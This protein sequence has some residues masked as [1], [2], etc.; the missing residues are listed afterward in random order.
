ML[1]PAYKGNLGIGLLSFWT[2][3]DPASAMT[4]SRC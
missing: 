1:E 3:G 4:F 2:V